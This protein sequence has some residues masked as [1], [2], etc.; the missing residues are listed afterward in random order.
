MTTR[1]CDA[2]SPIPKWDNAQCDAANLK[3]HRDGFATGTVRQTSVAQHTQ[4]SLEEKPIQE[5]VALFGELDPPL[6]DT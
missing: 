6:D 3:R 1:E 4:R 2:Y 5:A